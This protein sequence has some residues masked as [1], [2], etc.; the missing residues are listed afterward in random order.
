MFVTRAAAL[1]MII[2]C[3]DN[4]FCLGICYVNVPQAII[5]YLKPGFSMFNIWFSDLEQAHGAGE[6]FWK[7]PMDQRPG[8][9]IVDVG[10]YTNWSPHKLTNVSFGLHF[11]LP[12]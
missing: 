9:C 5:E 12:M 10:A 2:I 11:Q 3:P 7:L 1:T 8:G 4:E 6:W